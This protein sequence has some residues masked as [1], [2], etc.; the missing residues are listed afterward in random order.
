MTN[1]ECNLTLSMVSSFVYLTH[2]EGVCH[3]VVYMN[4][5]YEFIKKNDKVTT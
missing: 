1:L 2:G 4:Y 5:K 3:Y